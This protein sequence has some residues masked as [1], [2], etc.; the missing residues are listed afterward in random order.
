MKIANT[1]QLLIGLG[2]PSSANEDDHRD[3]LWL[4]L[5]DDVHQPEAHAPN[6]LVTNC[7]GSLSE[8]LVERKHT[9]RLRQEG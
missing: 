5:L 7:S 3:A 4:A 1:L 9:A 6:C 8:A 2:F